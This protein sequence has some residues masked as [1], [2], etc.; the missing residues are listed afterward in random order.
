MIDLIGNWTLLI[1][2]CTALV[3]AGL[4]AVLVVR[5]KEAQRQQLVA[6]SEVTR[7]WRTTWK[8]NA[9]ADARVMEHEKDD[10]PSNFVLRIE[11]NRMVRDIG[12]GEVMETRWRPPTKAE[13]REIVRRYHEAQS[14]VPR[15]KT[16]EFERPLHEGASNGSDRDGAVAESAKGPLVPER[17]IKS[18]RDHSPAGGAA[19]TP[20]DVWSLT[21]Q[22]EKRE[23]TSRGTAMS[24]H[25]NSVSPEVR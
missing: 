2:G 18:W 17:A 9:V 14:K 3:L 25:Q 16:I 10:I 1:V 23:A 20:G 21:D 24:D 5:H 13:V 8:I 19:E 11:E 7:D 15:F 22:Q 4:L 6:V 12:G